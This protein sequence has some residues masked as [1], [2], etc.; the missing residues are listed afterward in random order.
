[1]IKILV[2]YCDTRFQ[3]EIA[4]C[5]V[6][7]ASHSNEEHKSCHDEPAIKNCHNLIDP[8]NCHCPYCGSWIENPFSDCLHIHLDDPRII[9]VDE[10]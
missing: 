10:K 4:P 5:D 8:T 6:G 1:M 2:R 9:Q 7:W 3:N